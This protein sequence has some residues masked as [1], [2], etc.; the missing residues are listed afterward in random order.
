[1]LLGENCYIIVDD[2]LPV[3]SWG[4]LTYGKSKDGDEF[5]VSI[6]EKAYA[7][8]CGSYE[9]IEGGLVHIGLMDL[10]GGTGF[11]IDLTDKKTVEHI[12]NGKL[13]AD[14]LK[15]HNVQYLL[16]AGSPS[17]KDTDIR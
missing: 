3:T 8:F 1:M 16:G 5:W 15:Y 14:L 7:K 4:S 2:R 6:I 11:I 9:S 17:G 10:T 13:W 12:A